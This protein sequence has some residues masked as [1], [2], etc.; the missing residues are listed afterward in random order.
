[1]GR[2]Y[3]NFNSKMRQWELS[4]K[5]NQ[6]KEINSQEL[7]LNNDSFDERAARRKKYSIASSVFTKDGKLSDKL[8]CDPCAYT[9]INNTLGDDIFF[10]SIIDRYNKILNTENLYR[11]RPLID[12]HPGGFG[13]NNAETLIWQN[14]ALKLLSMKKCFDKVVNLANKAIKNKFGENAITEYGI[15]GNLRQNSI[16]E[17]NTSE[18]SEQY[19]FMHDNNF[20]KAITHA[21]KIPVE[22][23]KIVEDNEDIRKISQRCIMN[24]DGQI[25]L[26][27]STATIFKTE[28]DKSN[29]IQFD[30]FYRGLAEGQFRVERWD[31]LPHGTHYNIFLPAKSVAF[32]KGIVME[33]T[34]Y[35]HIHRRTLRQR[36]I[37]G[38]KLS[39]D[40]IP[41]P[42][43]DEPYELER[44]FNSFDDMCNCFMDNYNISSKTLDKDLIATIPLKE[45]GLSLCPRFSSKT[46][47]AAEDGSL[48]AESAEYFDPVTIRCARRFDVDRDTT[49]IEEDWSPMQEDSQQ[50]L[51]FDGLRDSSSEWLAR[52]LW[53]KRKEMGDMTSEIPNSY[54]R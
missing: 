47:R 32:I 37:F 20:L 51:R 4:A 6:E 46:R 10:E 52:R 1:M 3:K 34:K 33:N 15:S 14:R 35:S 48:S 41:V 45:L 30:V 26:G 21:P 29:S 9:D 54:E 53:K 38:S 13:K 36:V 22:K 28:T 16:P 8:Q 43:N 49:Q 11:V 17:I 44:K 27:A 19:L 18:Q 39:C 23:W 2:L 40:V 42:I 5:E 25:L 7:R 31:Y 24:I 50:S 12:I